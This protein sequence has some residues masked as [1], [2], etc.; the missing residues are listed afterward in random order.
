MLL[1]LLLLLRLRTTNIDRTKKVLNAAAV[2]VLAAVDAVTAY[3][4]VAVL[5]FPLLPLP[6]TSYPVY[7]CPPPSEPRLPFEIF[8]H[9]RDSGRPYLSISRCWIL[10]HGM[11]FQIVQV[12]HSEERIFVRTLDLDILKRINVNNLFGNV[13]KDVHHHSGKQSKSSP[14][15]TRG[16]TTTFYTKM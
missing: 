15:Q 8:T 2:A 13:S 5:S 9:H 6:S 12:P 10:V 4:N 7:W 14:G 16:L 3:C 11:I 1:L